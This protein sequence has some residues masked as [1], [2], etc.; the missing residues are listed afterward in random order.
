[1]LINIIKEL[2]TKK[3]EFDKVKDA[4]ADVNVSGYGVVTPVREV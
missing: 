4:L 2:S 3:N 1:M